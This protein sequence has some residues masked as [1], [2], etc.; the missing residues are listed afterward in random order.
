MERK[1]SEQQFLAAYDSY[2]EAIFRFCYFKTHDKELSQDLMQQTFL[3]TWAYLKDGH[4][5]ENLKAFIYKIAGN[6]VIDWYRKKKEQ[7]LEDLAEQGFDPVDENME[8]QRYAEAEWA[9]KSLD[10]LEPEDKDL[11]IWRYVES[12]T[13][14]EIADMLEQKVNTISVRIHRA[15]ERLKKILHEQEF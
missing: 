11:I 8:T 5:V 15:V 9:M 10:K 2:M 1:I 12:Y 13:P 3:K 4:E 14:K 7:S 6:L